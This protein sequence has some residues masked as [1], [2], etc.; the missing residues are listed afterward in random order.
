[1]GLKEGEE[2]GEGEE[3]RKAVVR[4]VGSVGVVMFGVGGAER[5][6]VEVGGLGEMCRGCCIAVQNM[7]IKEVTLLRYVC[8]Q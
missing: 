6:M 7:S 8:M 3:G 5:C 1:M 4:G 2:G